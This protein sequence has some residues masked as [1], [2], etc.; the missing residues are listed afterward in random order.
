MRGELRKIGI[1]LLLLPFCAVTF[2]GSSLH[3]LLDPSGECCTR[4]VRTI[5]D[6]ELGCQ[7]QNQ[8]PN[9][10]RHACCSAQSSTVSRNAFST[11]HGSSSFRLRST[12]SADECLLCRFLATKV[13]ATAPGADLGQVTPSRMRVARIASQWM[14]IASP[15]PQSPR[16][17][18]IAV[19]FQ[20]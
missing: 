12:H 17:P 13:I 3:R 4:I 2:F 20:A 16:A 7:V 6:G 5:A 14:A 19:S 9:C 18:P 8:A 11:I 1:L 10:C 15:R